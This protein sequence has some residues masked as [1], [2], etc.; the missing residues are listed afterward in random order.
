MDY[1]E[2]NGIST[3]GITGGVSYNL[4]IM[5]MVYKKVKKAGKRFAAHNRIPSG[6]GCIAVGQNVIAGHQL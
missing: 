6:D 5:D 4:P 3:I 1:A 2:V